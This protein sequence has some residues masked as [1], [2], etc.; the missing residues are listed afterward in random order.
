MEFRANNPSDRLGP[1]LGP[2][3]AVVRHMRAL[4][5]REV[6]SA[7]ETV[8]TWDAMPVA[9]LAFEFLVLTAARWGEVR[10]A[11]WAVPARRMKAKREHR[12]PLCRRATEILDAGRA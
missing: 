12:V 11:E 7:L 5:H 8:R 10:W 9:K 1:V 2:Q 3:D 6:A 4:P